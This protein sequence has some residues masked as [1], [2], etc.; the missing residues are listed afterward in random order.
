TDRLDQHAGRAAGAQALLADHQIRKVRLG[1][2]AFEQRQV[3]HRRRGVG[4]EAGRDDIAVDRRGDVAAIAAV[5]AEP[6]E[7][8]PDAAR[9]ALRRGEP[10]ADVDAA[11]AAAAADR[12]HGDAV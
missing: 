9:I 12:L 3:E 2:R 10:A 6:A 8:E 5:A 1:L 7:A 11:L 4:F